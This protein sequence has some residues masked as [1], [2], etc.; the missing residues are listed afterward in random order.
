[1]GPGR[2][3]VSWDIAEFKPMRGARLTA[4]IAAEV[5]GPT[6][7]LRV[8]SSRQTTEEALPDDELCF[9]FPGRNDGSGRPSEILCSSGA[10]RDG[11]DLSN[12]T[13]SGKTASAPGPIRRLTGHN[14]RISIRRRAN[15]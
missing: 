7:R 4:S 15:A 8:M 5:G 12:A 2:S 14:S 13:N 10:F 1:M 6:E 9:G 11:C 3:L